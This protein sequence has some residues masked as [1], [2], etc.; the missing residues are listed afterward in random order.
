[1]GVNVYRSLVNLAQDLGP[2]GPVHHSLQAEECM[3]ATC[4]LNIEGTIAACSQGQREVAGPSSHSLGSLD[5]S[6]K[7]WSFT[8]PNSLDLMACDY[9]PDIVL[10]RCSYTFICKNFKTPRK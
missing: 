2:Q 6:T 4:T 10:L 8:F 1:M 9:C 7:A 3:P 5:C